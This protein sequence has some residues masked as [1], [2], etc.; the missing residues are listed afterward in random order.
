[1]KHFS[2]I[3]LGA[4]AVMSSCSSRPANQFDLRGSIDGADGQT[5]YLRY[6]IGDS[7]VFDSTTVV[8]GT[9]VF[10]G[11]IN[12]PVSSVIYN[13]SLQMGNNATR[14]CILNLPR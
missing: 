12:E 1:M 5:I 13:G 8:N 14:K 9:F 3:A 2:I 10:T 7:V 6:A 11:N 4:V